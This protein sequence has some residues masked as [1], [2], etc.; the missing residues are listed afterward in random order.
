V[1]ALVCVLAGLVAAQAAFGRSASTVRITSRSPLVVVGS[2][3]APGTQLRLIVSGG[4]TAS[5]SLRSGGRGAF[6][7]RFESVRPSRCAAL[8]VVVRSSGTAVAR[9]FSKPAPECAEHVDG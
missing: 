1:R 5:R 9:G 6:T 7:V 2:G 4:S 3:F 8:S